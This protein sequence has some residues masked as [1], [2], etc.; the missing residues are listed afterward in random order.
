MGVLLV[1]LD[2]L[3]ERWEVWGLEAEH[4]QVKL[5][6]VEAVDLVVRLDDVDR[7]LYQV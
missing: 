6:L 3:Q 2:R 4:G 1:K 7:H 5:G